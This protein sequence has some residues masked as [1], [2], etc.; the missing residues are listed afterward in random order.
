M[1]WNEAAFRRLTRSEGVQNVLMAR[2]SEFADDLRENG[3]EATGA[4]KAS[5][6]VSMKFQDRA[7]ALVTIDDPKALIIEAQ[8]APVARAL[9]RSKQ[10]RR[11]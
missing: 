9:A 10:R 2:A 5:I 3:P 1:Q 11:A 8:L 7:V 6:G 4:W